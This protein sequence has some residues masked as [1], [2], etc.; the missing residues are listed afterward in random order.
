M[1]A[2][3]FA[4]FESKISELESSVRFHEDREQQLEAEVRDT[5]ERVRTGTFKP[6]LKVCKSTYVP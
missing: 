4:E 6:I 1:L 5:E 2:T 3:S